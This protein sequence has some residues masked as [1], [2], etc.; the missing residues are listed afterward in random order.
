MKLKE[1]SFSC[2]HDDQEKKV[3][4][5]GCYMAP[6]GIAF[7]SYISSIYSHEQ[8]LT[9]LP[10]VEDILEKMTEDGGRSQAKK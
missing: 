4:L 6:P 7:K 2:W 5:H 1:I 9:S 8:P 3:H 10:L